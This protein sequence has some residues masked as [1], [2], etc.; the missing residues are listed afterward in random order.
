M[1]RDPQQA[2]KDIMDKYDT[3]AAQKDTEDWLKRG[4]SAR[5]PESKSAYYFIDRKVGEAMKLYHYS[6]RSSVVEIGCSF[7]EMTYLLA[8]KFDRVVAIDLSPDAVRLARK[9]MEFYRVKNVSFMNDDAEKLDSLENESADVIFSFSTIRYCP[10]PQIALNKIFHKLAENGCAIIDFPNKYSPWHVLLK[11]L[12]LIKKHIHD[13]LFS[14]NDIIRMYRKAGF[15]DI[16]YKFF[17]FTTRRLPDSLLPVSIV[18]DRLLEIMP[19]IRNLAGI[20]MVK[21]VKSA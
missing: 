9:R 4:D 2:K 7:G 12:L 1:K 13:N 11:P 18:L 20:I 16:E 6:P 3:S 14:L 10:N 21:G 15:R 17:L 8:K 19:G 5:V